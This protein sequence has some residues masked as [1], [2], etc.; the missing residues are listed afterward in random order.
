MLENPAVDVR[1]ERCQTEYE[2]ED[3]SVSEEGTQVQ[4]MACG[5][6]FLVTRPAPGSLVEP[7]S[8]PPAE[9]LLETS[10]GQAHRFRN[11]TSLQKWIIERKVTRDDRISRTGHAWRRLGEIVELEPFFDVVDEAD[12]ARAASLSAQG[13]A[14]KNQAQ[15][16]RRSSPVRVPSPSDELRSA[17]LGSSESVPLDAME[18][19]R[20]EMQTAVVTLGGGNLLKVLLG[21][22]VAA[23]VAYVGITQFWKRPAVTARP[24]VTPGPTKP[25][26][27][28]AEPA[29]RPEPPPV[30]APP[31]MPLP[32]ALPP[33]A[34]P[35]APPPPAPE[36]KPEPPVSFEKLVADADHQLEN[37]S[38][39]KARVLYERALKAKP[40]AAEALAGLGY[41]AL[42]H[43]RVPQAF[44]LFKRALAQK[45]SFGP[46]IFG[47]AEAHRTTGDEEIAISHYRR[48]IAVDPGG[49][50]VPAARQHIKTL[51][52]RLAARG[53]AVSQPPPSP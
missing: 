1:C 43:G 8:P 37:G 34:P 36:A 53:S 9:W 15:A 45:P 41:V 49:T 5:N 48:Y 29:P 52:A 24:P 42:D 44:S 12:K 14:L 7:D 35:P 32:A 31:P 47:L 2:L 30:A 33:A 28:M 26:V 25:T 50:D 38:S 22:I 19:E 3:S 6:T 51:E 11:L 16:A 39:E 23:L 10:D 13:T 46:A 21:L 40:G 4:C 18:P 17:P 27:V 20:P